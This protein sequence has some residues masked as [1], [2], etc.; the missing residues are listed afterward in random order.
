[1]SILGMATPLLVPIATFF[2]FTK[3][4]GGTLDAATAFTSL[5]IFAMLREPLN[6]I[7][8]YMVEIISA[9]ACLQRISVFLD[10]E[11]IPEEEQ[12]FS[13]SHP[14]IGFKNASFQW[15]SACVDTTNIALQDINLEFPRGQLSIIC[16]PVGSG[17]TSL[18][19]ALLGE[20]KLV[21]GRRFLP[22]PIESV[23]F[24][25]QQGEISDDCFGT[26]FIRDIFINILSHCI[27]WLQNASI[28]ENI[29]FGLPFDKTRYEEVLEICALNPDCELWR[30]RDLTE[31]GEK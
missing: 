7:P 18:L 1:M 30:D 15:H 2:S 23:A 19:L 20:M 3:I 4:Y 25:S 6:V 17:K 28:R 24:V 13:E 16:G 9:S 5:A 11:E 26:I 22:R 27:V 10:E 12:D 29:T 21:S 31:I 8:E 14:M